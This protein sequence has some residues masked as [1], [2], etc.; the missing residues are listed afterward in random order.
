[1]KRILVTQS[2]RKATEEVASVL[3]EQGFEVEDAHDIEE[4]LQKAK[5]EPWD[6]IILDIRGSE[7]EFFEAFK[8]VREHT[9]SPLVILSGL[10]QEEYIVKGLNAGADDYLVKPISAKV[11]LAHVFAILRRASQK[12]EAPP[13]GV[14][15]CGDLSID[16]D[17][18]EVRV[19][20]RP[21]K[22]TASEFRLLSYLAKNP[23]R[24]LTNKELVREVQGYEASPQEARDIIKVHIH[25]LRKK[26]GLSPEKPPY[27]KNVRGVGYMFERRSSSRRETVNRILT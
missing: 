3:M 13:S 4:A 10:G 19:R 2:D 8:D 22:L 1:M 11:F 17:R 9:T 18:Y 24:V 14:L 20:D 7:T 25:N 27:I 15:K 6:L 16:F 26:L 5:S 23:G 12:D 21:V